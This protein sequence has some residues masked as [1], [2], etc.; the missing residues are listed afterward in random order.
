MQYISLIVAKVGKEIRIMSDEYERNVNFILCLDDN[1][2]S[3]PWRLTIGM[4]T[5]QFKTREEGL[6]FIADHLKIIYGIS[7]K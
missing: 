2:K 7:A 5:T 3:L 1:Y 6:Q 4:S